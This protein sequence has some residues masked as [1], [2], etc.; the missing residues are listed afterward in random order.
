MRLR[1]Q[2]L[3]GLLL[4][5]L[6]SP[7]TWAKEGAPADAFLAQ[8]PER[9]LSVTQAAIEAR[10]LHIAH[11]ED[12]LGVPTVLWNARLD[13]DR[14][15]RALANQSPEAAARAHLAR[16]ADLY[17]LER[18]D[19][20]S[21]VLH[22]IHQPARGPVVVRFTQKVEGIEVF[23]SGFNVAM[24]RDNALVAITGYM[25][26]HEAT[27]AR[28]R[29]VGTDFALGAPEAVARAFKDLT[30]TALSGRSLVSAGSQGE[31]AHFTFEPGVASVLPHAMAVPARA[32]KVYFLMQ[33]GLEPAWYLELNV[34]AK[35]SSDSDYHSFVVSA[36][37]GRQLFRN[38]LTVEDSYSYRVWAEPSSFIPYDG[39]QGNGATPHPTGTPN[40]HQEPFV[41]PNLI[42]LEN[43]PFSRNDPWLPPGATQTTGNNVEAYAD[44]AAPDGFQPG[45]DLRADTTAPGVF[46]YTYDVTQAPGSSAIQ[47]KAAVAHLF[48]LN[49][50]LHDW[51]YDSGFDEA[52]GNAQLVNYGRG[53]LEGD[54]LKAE[55]QDY[56]GRNNANMSTPADGARPR[57]QMYVFDGVPNVRVTAPASVAGT[58][59][60][61]SA[62]WGKLSYDLTGDLV[63]PNPTGITEGCEPFPANAFSGKLVL[64]DRGTCNYTIKAINAQNA[65]AIGIL[66][67]NN[68]EALAALSL[69][70]ADPAVT[71]AAVGITQAAGNALKNEVKNNGSTITV[72][73]QKLAEFDRDGTIDNAI[74]AHEWGHYIS[75]RLV[76]N[77]NG[78]TN[79]QGRAMGEGWADFHAMLM[80]VRE[81]DRNRPGNSSFQ[82]VY[83]M[84][85]Y[86]QSGGANNGY[87]FGIRRLPYSTDFNKNALTYRHFATGSPLPTTH[88][89]SASSMAGLGNSQVHAGGEVWSSMLW[90]CYASLL[91]AYPFQE[92]Q[93]RMKSY[94][95]AAYKMTPNAPTLL[96]ARDAVLAVAAAADPADYARFRAAFAKRGAGV[97]AK[98]ADRGAVD[99]VG[100]VE[101]FAAGSNLEV[102]SIR[103]DDS[104]TG[105]DRDGVLD[106]GETGLLHVT[107][108][109]TS[110]TALSSFTSTVTASGATAALA[111][112]SG[113][114]LSFP[115][116]QPSATVTR[117]L[118]V[119]LDSVTPGTE[120]RAGLTVT[121]D[122]PSLPTAAK[123]AKFNGRVHADELLAQST[124]ETFEAAST[125]WVSAPVNRWVPQTDK[126]QD[127]TPRRYFHVAN[128]SILSDLTLTSPWIKVNAT[129]NFVLAYKYRHSLE[130]T[131]G[132]AGPAAP[133]YDGVTLEATTDGVTWE[134]VLTKYGVNPGFASAALAAGDNPL[135]GQRAYSGLNAAFPDWSQATANFGT[136]LAGK[137]VRFRFRI[138]SDSS[139]GA[140]GFDLD[141][142][143]VTNAA[144]TPF[145]AQV[146]E[147]ST[148]PVCNRRPVADVGQAT[149]SVPEASVVGGER[150]RNTVT[151][152]GTG[153][154]DPDGNPLTYQWTQL[155][156]P[157][158]T[159]SSPTSATP[160][161][162]TVEVSKTAVLAFQLIVN[163]GTDTSTPKVTEVAITNVNTKPVAAIT[164]PA[165]VASGS[166][167]PV[168]LNGGGSTDADG[169]TLTYA[170][171]QTAGPTVAL[172]STTTASVSFLA[173]AV[174]ADAVLTFELVVRDG[175]INSDPKAFSV[176]VTSTPV[177]RHP[178]GH[179]P[180]NFSENEGTAILLDAS[181]SEDPDGDALSFQWT[182]EGG[183]SL[184]L[185]GADTSKLAFTAPEVLADTKLLFVLV[186]KDAAGA[187]S[188][189]VPVTVTVLNVNKAPVAHARKQPSDLN[190]SSLTLEASSSID[191]DGDALTYRWE[192]VAGPQV[193]LSSTTAPTVSFDVPETESATQ[194]QFK[195]TVTDPSGASG[196][197]V[198]EVLVLGDKKDEDD[199][200]GCSSTGDSAGSLMVLSL[201][202]GVLLSRRRQLPSA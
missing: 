98:A 62:A 18:G 122:E 103:L 159:L 113:N 12:R 170:W 144:S 2:V 192:Q 44:L 185:T 79:N 56:S 81:E 21:A 69:G 174:S 143:T 173:P 110:T 82:G 146:A 71:L 161:F 16:A 156:G 55:A 114:T 181:G 125:Q 31:F 128:A 76:G 51:Y 188:A 135:Q 186:V 40:A 147:P 141:D 77:A 28:R 131:V 108:R 163:D 78:L 107:V 101:S 74:V 68:V 148:G 8:R 165:S 179:V 193:T 60:A 167:T 104:V 132:G 15:T 197:D 39:P 7:A 73:L 149:L 63:V 65:G 75:N 139:T 4:V 153:S 13:S 118:Q 91:N 53:G 30:D 169:D 121:F 120:P 38:N 23:R 145:S 134:H 41:A 105:C 90:E 45:V 189:P 194:L 126:E 191:P 183:P 43:V 6:A 48:Y 87:Y 187:E 109:N 86:T 171:R 5:P 199:S 116:L 102:V 35:G 129:G 32:K 115:T 36:V 162:Q 202:A 136:Q 127:G 52:S 140:Y 166:T 72:K 19:I 112:P 42:T 96:E 20:S 158:V 175:A 157:A 93:D 66:V 99:H 100:V 150:V 54:S 37:D 196:S 61:G 1:K 152:N 155:S 138:G 160:T 10:G 168:T 106:V 25:A 14:G 46:D 97:G 178:V 123:T 177:N 164:G 137:D 180:E 67:A 57:M 151:L 47:R 17:R 154:V 83:A 64:L 3:T 26:P 95:L 80:T 176:T 133:W 111:F 130:G 190:A 94:L 9:T 172:S 92:A 33:D 27:A 184:N 85:G 124:T 117:T 200:S 195:L 182:Q 29:M 49:N 11:T 201:L 34:G 50:F 59:D 198:V 58:L 89:I 24:T 119:K 84:A 88:P 22:S 70:G 142:V